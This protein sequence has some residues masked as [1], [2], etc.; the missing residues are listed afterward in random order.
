MA[1][2]C[3]VVFYT[4]A[5][6]LV[7]FCSPPCTRVIAQL[8]TS[9]HLAEPGFWPTQNVV[10]RKDFVGA[11]TCAACHASIFATQKT[12]PMGATAMHAENSDILH[13]HPKMNF[14][15][16]SYHYEVKTEGNRTA[17][18]IADGKDAETASLLWA[19]GT[20]RVGQSYLF[21]KQDEQFYEARVTFFS[22]LQNLHFTPGRAMTSAKDLE[23]AMYREVSPGE[24]G[25]CFA[26]HTTASSIAGKF[27]EANLIPGVTCEACHG[28]G[29]EHVAAM[30]AAKLTGE[31]GGSTEI[32]NPASL[33]PPDSVDFC[34]ACHATTWDVKLSGNKGVSNARSQPYR[35]E[36]SKCWGQGDPRL[37]CLGCHDPHQ[38][39]QTEPVSY[40][41]TCLSCHATGAKTESG[42]N[43]NKVTD[44]AGA[45]C[46][47][48]TKNCV[49]CHMPKL[50]VPEMHHEFTD[51]KIRIVKPGDQY[52]D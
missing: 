25:R 8:S 11:E 33:H 24:I 37:T 3:K 1:R 47:V 10:S 21:K 49:T 43:T 5:V 48:A 45:A 13:S 15:F 29:A 7:L 35:L 23:D 18:S 6:V 20:G 46:P 17:Y 22:S 4:C 2:F 31:S 36:K 12:T 9:D 51:H 38:Q 39:L 50:E 44:H 42:A 14:N 30:N 27:D 34:G 28:P 41:G 52:T 19:F 40:D 26:C 32:F 16:G